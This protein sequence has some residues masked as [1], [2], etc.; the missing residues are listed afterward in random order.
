[1]LL[2]YSKKYQTWGGGRIK[3]SKEEVSELKKAKK[4]GGKKLHQKFT[5]KSKY[6]IRGSQLEFH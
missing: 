6:G 3:T 4:E 5:N 2:S 1:M